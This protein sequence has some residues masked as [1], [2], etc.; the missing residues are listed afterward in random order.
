MAAGK[1]VAPT[2]IDSTAIVREVHRR[3]RACGKVAR[4]LIAKSYIPTTMKVFGATVPDL[5]AVVRDLSKQL[6][7]AEPGDVIRTA[8]ALVDGGSLEGRQVG[9]E[10][11]SHHQG[12]MAA[13]GTRHLARLGKGIDNWASV[14]GL[15]CLVS[16]PV[17]REGQVP[18][19]LVHKWARSKDRWW[20][21]AA[22][23]STVALN[24]K[25]RGGSGDT[26]R[27]LD[28]CKRVAK[29]H[30]DMVAKG[31]SWALRELSMRDPK[32]V[33]KFLREHEAVLAKRV[34]REV[35]NKLRTGL[36]TPGNR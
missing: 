26:K 28:I 2:T 15:A 5:R 24:K 25:S 13:L 4:R 33:Q 6:R 19:S 18:D 35:R 34:L 36:K 20:R 17:W 31:L 27:T 14:D 21:R 32:S 3:L 29:D 16:G 9:Y 8:Q 30:D 10:I 23:V 7:K 1:A 11:L 12:A 22:I